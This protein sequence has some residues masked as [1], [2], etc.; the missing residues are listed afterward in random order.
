MLEDLE[1]TKTLLLNQQVELARQ[2]REIERLMPKKRTDQDYTIIKQKR[3]KKGFVYCAKYYVNGKLLPTKF[4]LKTT[5]L[6]T[7]KKERSL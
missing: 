3:K 5:N 4:S 7:A 2:L 6:E 1:Q